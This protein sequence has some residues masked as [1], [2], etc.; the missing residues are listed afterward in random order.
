[1]TDAFKAYHVFIVFKSTSE[2][3]DDGIHWW[4]L[5]KNTEY[6]VLQRCRN[7]ENVKEKFKGE[8]RNKVKLIK[9]DLKGKG[10]IQDLFAILWSHQIIEKKYLQHL[11]LKLPVFRHFRQQTN[12]RNR[13]QI[14]GEF[15]VFS[16]S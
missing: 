15:Q 10:T 6:I 9:E 7:K 16:S 4:S 5:E 8:E 1:M 13:I 3:A 12:Y 14:Q 2:T 11:E